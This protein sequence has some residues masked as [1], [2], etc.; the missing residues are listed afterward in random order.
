MVTSGFVAD[1]ADHRDLAGKNRPR[2]ALVVKAPQ[3]FQ[4]AAAA[5]TIST[6]HS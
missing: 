1:G 3:I 5:P 2:H 4:R 6:S